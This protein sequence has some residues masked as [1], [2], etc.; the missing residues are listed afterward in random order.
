MRFWKKSAMSRLGYVALVS[1]LEVKE[2]EREKTAAQKK[3]DAPS[4]P[5][6]EDQTEL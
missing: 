6:L 3:S 4:V 1:G 2:R 5:L